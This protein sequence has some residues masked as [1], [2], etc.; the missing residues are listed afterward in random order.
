MGL[1]RLIL[2]AIIIGGGI[3]L[4]RR[5]NNRNSS[6]SQ[7]PATHTMVRCAHCHVHLPEN[8]AIQDNQQHWFCSSAHRSLG[9]QSRD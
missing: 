2:L 5:F 6:T 3:W 4:W 9:P 7:Q 1:P 8:R